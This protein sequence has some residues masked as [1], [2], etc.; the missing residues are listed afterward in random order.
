MWADDARAHVFMRHSD[1]QNFGHIMVDDFLSA[2]TAGARQQPARPNVYSLHYLFHKTFT[3]FNHRSGRAFL[4][5]AA[6]ADL[7]LVLVEWCSCCR[8][9]FGPAHAETRFC[10]RYKTHGGWLQGL[11][12]LDSQQLSAYVSPPRVTIAAW[13]CLL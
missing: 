8:T 11:T 5:D 13:K 2:Y 9:G 12:P 10:K 4:P 3:H 7:R 1:P 6:V